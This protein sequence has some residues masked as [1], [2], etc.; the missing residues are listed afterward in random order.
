M[1]GPTTAVGIDIGGTH[2]RAARVSNAGEIEE[3]LSERVPIDRQTLVRRISALVDQL[4]SGTEYVGIGVPGRVQIHDQI[5]LSAG[6]VDLANFPLAATVANATGKSVF[7]DNDSRM[8]LIAERVI[9]AAMGLD[10]VVMLTIGTGVGGA[11]MS[12]GIL[13]DGRGAAGQLG[14]LTI[15]ME[16]AACRC[17]RRG[18]LETTS[19]GTALHRLLAD[20]ALSADLPIERLFAL[21]A[22]GDTGA[23]AVLDQWSRPL[24]SAVDSLVAAFDPELMLLGGGLGRWAYQALQRVPPGSAWYQCS[25]MPAK[26]GDEAGVIGAALQALSRTVPQRP[27]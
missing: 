21:A 16:G 9:G 18:C 19:S 13:L 8:A 3:H 25:V 24:R 27:Q 1:T 14:H 20:A 10:E 17:G 7:I 23:R 5:V 11:V 22:E 2:L 15:D 6:F 4:G 12:R 26:L